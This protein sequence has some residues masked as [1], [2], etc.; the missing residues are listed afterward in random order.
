[1]VF[2]ADSLFFVRFHFL[3]FPYFISYTVFWR[4]YVIFSYSG[5]L[6]FLLCLVSLLAF[7]FPV[8]AFNLFFTPY[9]FSLPSSSSF[10]FLFTQLLFLILF[11]KSGLLFYSLSRFFTCSIFPFLYIYF[12][13]FLHTRL[14]FI[15]F[16]MLWFIQF[17]LSYY[18]LFNSGLPSL[19]A[20]RLLLF[21]SFSCYFF[22]IFVF[23]PCDLPIFLPY[24]IYI[25]YLTGG[26]F[27]RLF[28][29]TKT[30][31][32][33]QDRCFNLNDPKLL[34]TSFTCSFFFKDS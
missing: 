15:R 6:L 16:S 24:P 3:R 23:R 27:T 13:I 29:V 12:V 31:S 2:V 8:F 26:K 19:F 5:F 17:F 11:L 7:S 25:F 22:T 30:G 28:C 1:M 34:T 32:Q 21:T 20:F 33:E 14:H 9:S 4:I 10:F 18:F